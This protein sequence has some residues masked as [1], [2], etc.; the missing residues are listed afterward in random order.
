MLNK[1][2]KQQQ[3]SMHFKYS[4][5][6]SLLMYFAIILTLQACNY[7]KTTYTRTPSNTTIQTLESK[8]LIVHYAEHIWHLKQPLFNDVQQKL[9]GKIEPLSNNHQQYQIL[10]KKNYDRYKKKIGQPINEV[11]FFVSELAEA[12]DSTI[13]IPYSCIQGVATN[14]KAKGVSAAA[15]TIIGIPVGILTYFT[16]AFIN[17]W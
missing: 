15:Y 5:N 9:S 6:I 16:I 11:H 7:Y 8:Y 1:I 14:E 13:F 10:K 12:P 4:K 17:A 3:N 2:I